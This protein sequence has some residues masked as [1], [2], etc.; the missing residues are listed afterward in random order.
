M[1][2]PEVL[3]VLLPHSSV[4]SKCNVFDRD[5]RSVQESTQQDLLVEVRLSLT[6]KLAS[7]A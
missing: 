5:H 1:A 6:K 3:M 4:V 7:W 2:P